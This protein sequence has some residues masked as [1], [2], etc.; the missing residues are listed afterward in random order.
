[1]IR[2]GGLARIELR[3]IG[4]LV[5]SHQRLLAAVRH[6]LVREGSDRIAKVLG[7]L[8]L[9]MVVI[10]ELHLLLGLLRQR[11]LYSKQMRWVIMA[12]HAQTKKEASKL[13]K[14]K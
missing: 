11:G 14:V 9:Y 10:L 7:Y 5:H 1:M 12:K 8:V 2:G 6:N 3:H 13:A 4:V